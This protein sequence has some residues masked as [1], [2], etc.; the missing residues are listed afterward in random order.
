[1]EHKPE[2]AAVYVRI[3]RDREGAG[4]GVARQVEDC[5]ALAERLGWT[6]AEVITDNDVSAHDRKKT[7]HGY[8]RLLRG[9]QDGAFDGVLAWH[10]DR[11]N[12][13]SAELE[14][15][16]TSVEDHGVQVATVQGGALDLSTPDGRMTARLLGAIAGRE[17]EHGR[18]RIVR[19]KRQA[20]EAGRWRGGR[21]PFG[22]EPDGVT[23]REDEAAVVREACAGVLAGRSLKGMARE[24]AGRG[25]VTTTGKPF[26]ET[27][28][29]AVLMRARN[30]AL[31]EHKGEIVGAAQWSA[32]VP[33]DTWRA[34]RGVLTDP[35]RV[36]PSGEHRAH[37]L[38]GIAVCGVCGGP[39][40]MGASRNGRAYRCAKSAGHVVRNAERLDQYVRDVVVTV[41]RRPEGLAQLVSEPESSGVDVEALREE[42][43]V[44]EGRLGQLAE[45]YAEGLLN[46]AQVRAATERLEGKREKLQ[47]EMDRATRGTGME[48]VLNAADPGQMF[49]DAPLDRQR[50]IARALVVPVVYPAGRGRPAGWKPGEPYFDPS[51]VEFRTPGGDG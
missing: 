31:I 39:L 24:F 33:E 19:A 36:T 3:S 32:L 8:Q 13:R 4:L 18:D 35:A 28:L 27:T 48:D 5:Q 9:I 23:V 49:L 20:A 40:R 10:S 45:D 15:F 42:I 17:V 22:Y 38:S 2:H 50:A 41:L 14:E 30:A 21:R 51:R 12:R 26:A 44:V 16:I 1:M 7:R 47:A 25:V 11:L 34:V 46:G 29:R 43:G 6:V 37:L